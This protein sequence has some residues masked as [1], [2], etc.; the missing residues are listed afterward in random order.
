MFS[1]RKGIH[2]DII[3]T[4]NAGRGTLEALTLADDCILEW[5]E[6]FRQHGLDPNS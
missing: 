2:A 3:W 6:F 4:S 5:Q 1:D